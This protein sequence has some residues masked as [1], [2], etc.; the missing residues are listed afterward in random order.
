MY[1]QNKLLVGVDPLE[2]VTLA[3]ELLNSRFVIIDEYH[4]HDGHDEARCLSIEWTDDKFVVIDALSG[5]RMEAVWNHYKTEFESAYEAL[6][7]A[8]STW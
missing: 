7:Y 8:L 2:L 6:N 3:D 5:G 1:I 4:I